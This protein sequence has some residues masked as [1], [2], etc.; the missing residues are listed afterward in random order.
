M[1]F[2]GQL[3]LDDDERPLEADVEFVGSD[4]T[5]STVAGPMGRWPLEKCRIQPDNGRFLITIEEDTAWFVPDDSVRF[6]RLVLEHWGASSLASA[7][8][9]AR[10]AAG[11]LPIQLVK[12]KPLDESD[13]FDRRSSVVDGLAGLDAKRKWQ[14]AAAALGLILILL[15]ANMFGREEVAP[16][17]LGTVATTT[18]I[19][20]TPF[21]FQTG[22]DG[23]AEAWNDAASQLGLEVFLLEVTTGNRLQTSMAGDLVLYGTENPTTDT[24]HSL[25]ISAGP[26]VGE[27]ATAVLAVWG[28]LIAIVNPE[29]DPEG[30]RSVLERLGVD[31][32]R[33]L[34]LGLNAA[35]T[36]AGASYWL[37]SGV[38]NDRV[39][40]GAQPTG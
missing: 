34:T 5:V 7:M 3:S 6:T 1:P 27:Q 13:D 38:L 2:S 31:L 15:I 9:A 17:V 32:G 11:P 14:V 40:F 20:K 24:V 18:T 29:L 12:S 35:T 25:M 22:L 36:E 16:L 37:R 30:R 39:L 19:P 26:A 23:V 33:P 10:A 8:K 28:N 4:L 21:V